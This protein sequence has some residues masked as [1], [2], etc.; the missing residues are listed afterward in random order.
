MPTSSAHDPGRAAWPLGRRLA[1]AQ[2]ALVAL[3][4]AAS[5]ST[6]LTVRAQKADGLVINLAGRQRMLTQK[7]TK[8]SLAWLDA[9]HQDTPAGQEVAA[10]AW[11]A[12]D[13]SA[14]LFETTLSA[15]RDGGESYRNL[16]LSGPV[17]VPA[18]GNGAIVAQL[19][20]VAA[21]W[22]ALTGAVDDLIAAADGQDADA[23]TAA[24]ARVMAQSV[25]ALKNMNAAVVMYQA[26][27]EARVGTLIAMQ[28]G[29]VGV[30]LLAFVVATLYVVRRVSRPI[31]SVIAEL[32]SGSSM[33]AD[34]S[35]SVAGSS[36][37]LAQQASDQAARLEEAAASL[38][39][40]ASITDGNR[41]VTDTVQSLTGDV[42]AASESGRQ[43]IASLKQAMEQIASSSRDTAQIIKTIDEIA[44]QT[45]LL[46]LNAAV[47]AARAGDA[48]KGFAVVAEEVRNLAQR[49]AEAA[50]NSTSML[51]SSARNVE[52]GEAA[53]A[54]V[55]EVFDRIADG[56]GQVNAKIGEV[57]DA[58]GRQADEV[59]GIRDAVAH[60]DQ[61]TQS[62]AAN[63]EESAASAEELSAQAGQID[64]VVRDLVGI[65][66]ASYAAPVAA[67][68]A[69]ALPDAPVAPPPAPTAAPPRQEAPQDHAVI[70]LDED[71]LVDI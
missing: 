56:I 70:P 4:L 58:S 10:G 31:E 27:S 16:D 51:E 50:R 64:G 42:H 19:D 48:G 47:E 25:A 7:Y 5:F 32:K 62:G 52:T 22:R 18:T 29:A 63:A 37:G 6:L 59:G 1:L 66:G 40:L 15:L 12:R 3:L 34:T 21:E 36:T 55:E 23:E 61:L 20:K 35:V 46:A 43:S 68:P 13:R 38:E 14:K 65:V 67:A 44:F 17:R 2:G 33:L 49:S 8:E 45:N 28:Y 54:S 26:D 11:A 71:E 41:R 53:T 39:V 60:L 57:A 69:P 24:I 30:A 9:R